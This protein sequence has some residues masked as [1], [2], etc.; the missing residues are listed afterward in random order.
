MSNK[1]VCQVSRRWVDVGSFHTRLVERFMNFTASA[2]KILDTPSYVKSNAYLPNSAEV[3]L[4]HLL[5]VL[6][7]YCLYYVS[8][9]CTMY[10]LFVLCIY[11]RYLTPDYFLLR[12]RAAG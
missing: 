9:V 4:M 5:S 1:S 2:R 8:I 12:C 11:C 7:I 10:L 3:I 6:C